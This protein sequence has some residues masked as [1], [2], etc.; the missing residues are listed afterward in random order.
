MVT[1]TTQRWR[2]D[3][4]V[5][6]LETTGLPVPC[7]VRPVKIACVGNSRILRRLGALCAADW[8]AVR[9]SFTRY[10]SS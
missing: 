10:R 5:T 8:K 3:G 7:V 4:P 2:C 1:S 9:A 6:D